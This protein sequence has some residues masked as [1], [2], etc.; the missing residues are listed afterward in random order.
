MTLIDIIHVV[1]P[2]VIERARRMEV[3][4]SLLREGRNRREVSGLIQVRFRVS[5]QTA[6]R[7]VD[8]ASDI[9]EEVAA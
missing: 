6:W 9:T 2:T 8:A 5:Q 1:D 7:L 3:A 4:M